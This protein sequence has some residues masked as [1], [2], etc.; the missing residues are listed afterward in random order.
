MHTAV[1]P[2]RRAYSRHARPIGALVVATT[3][4]LLG[5]DDWLSPLLEAAHDPNAV[6]RASAATTGRGVIRNPGVR[7]DVVPRVH[8]LRNRA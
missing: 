7:Q 5:I 2:L 6:N 1:R 3:R 8:I 4:Q